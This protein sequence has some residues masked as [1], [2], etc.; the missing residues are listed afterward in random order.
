M[1][2]SPQVKDSRLIE[3]CVV[4]VLSLRDMPRLQPLTPAEDLALEVVVGL[5]RESEPCIAKTGR[6]RKEQ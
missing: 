6:P 4:K 1:S 2:D 3:R 5:L